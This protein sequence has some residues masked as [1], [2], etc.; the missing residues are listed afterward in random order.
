LWLAKIGY[1]VLGHHPSPPM[2]E[3]LFICSSYVFHFEW[4][5]VLWEC[6]LKL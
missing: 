1:G 4:F 2:T 5:K 6:C 3:P